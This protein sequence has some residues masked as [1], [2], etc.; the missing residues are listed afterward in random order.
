MGYPKTGNLSWD[1]LGYPGISLWRITWY[2]MG[3]DGI[4]LHMLAG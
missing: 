2:K 4:S 1:I 3:Y